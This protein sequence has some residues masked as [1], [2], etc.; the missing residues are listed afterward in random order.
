MFRY[1][2]RRGKAGGREIQG[3]GRSS[4]RRENLKKESIRNINNNYAN[5]NAN[6]TPTHTYTTTHSLTHTQPPPHTPGRITNNCTGKLSAA[7][8]DVNRCHGATDA[9][10]ECTRHMDIVIQITLVISIR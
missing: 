7:Y 5:A 9:V 4:R 2:T 10:L 1:L 8:C 3:K 6:R